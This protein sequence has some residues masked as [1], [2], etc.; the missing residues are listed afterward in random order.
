MRELDVLL[1]LVNHLL[2]MVRRIELLLEKL[3]LLLQLFYELHHHLLLMLV[4]HS[5]LLK[6]MDLG[7]VIFY[8]PRDGFVVVE[9][10]NVLAHVVFDFFGIRAES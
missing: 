5:C 9:A 2:D 1:L 7:L 8:H 6:L 4:L 3:S 10:Y